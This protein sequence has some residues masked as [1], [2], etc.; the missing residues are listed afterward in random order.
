MNISFKEQ[1]TGTADETVEHMV[2][3]GWPRDRAQE[4]VDLAKHARAKAIEAIAAVVERAADPMT[5]AQ[6]TMLAFGQLK[7][8]ADT[9]IEASKKFVVRLGAIQSEEDARRLADDLAE[10]KL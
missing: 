5:T 6:A 8:A 1:V 7:A 3:H 10:N 4:A 9:A 2:K